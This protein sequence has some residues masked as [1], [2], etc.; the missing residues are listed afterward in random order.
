[1]KKGTEIQ[2]GQRLG[3]INEGSPL[4]L[5]CLVEGGRPPPT[6]SWFGS[7]IMLEDQTVVVTRSNYI[8]ADLVLPELTRS[9]HLKT[10]TCHAKNNNKIN[11]LKQD[12]IIDMNLR[13]LSTKIILPESSLVANSTADFTCESQ[14]SKPQAQIRW[15]INGEYMDPTLAQQSSAGG[16]VT[17]S[18]LQLVP[19]AEDNNA[20][21]TCEAH[22]P[23]MQ[24]KPIKD[25]KRINVQ[26]QPMVGLRLGKSIDH[27]NIKQ[28]DDVYF[29]CKVDSNPEPT[30]VV[31]YR[32]DQ[33]IRLDKSG[34]VIVQDTSLALQNLHRKSAG[35]YQ[36]TATNYLGTTHSNA[37]DLD[38]KYA[39]VCMVDQPTV[40]AVGRGEKVDISCRV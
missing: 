19:Q 23:R 38:V 26:Y 5:S 10:F 36:C 27:S 15:K 14:G 37:V 8:Q 7:K 3:P 9:D 16:D 1:D 6:V 21:I 35:S 17:T 30:R 13:P 22:N 40:L 12:V 11:P 32:D 2:P 31:W 39:P 33:E 24:V 20:T 4:T 29:E 28:G 34:G 25:D 18:K